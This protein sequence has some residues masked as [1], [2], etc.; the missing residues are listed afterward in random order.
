MSAQCEF[1]ILLTKHLFHDKTNKSKNKSKSIIIIKADYL[2]APKR[3]HDND[4]EETNRH[5]TECKRQHLTVGQQVQNM[6]KNSQSR[7]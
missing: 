2:R 6:I 4:P 5:Y 7:R 3:G 1:K